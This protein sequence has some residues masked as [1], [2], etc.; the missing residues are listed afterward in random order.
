MTGPRFSTVKISTIKPHF[1]TIWA[2]S[3]LITVGGRER[4]GIMFWRGELE[5]EGQEGRGRRRWKANSL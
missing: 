1:T 5:G 4:T 2:V 3:S